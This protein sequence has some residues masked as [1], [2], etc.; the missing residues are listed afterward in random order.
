MSHSSVATETGQ[1]YISEQSL[2]IKDK[3]LERIKSL[4]KDTFIDSVL[5]DTGHDETSLSRIRNVL[6]QS[7]KEVEGF[8]N[9]QLIKRRKTRAGISLEH[10]LANDCY[11]LCIYLQGGTI[12]ELSDL[13]VCE[14][15]P[16]DICLSQSQACDADNLPSI[17]T[18]ESETL[19]GIRADVIAI[20]NDIH[21]QKSSSSAFD[22]KTSAALKNIKQANENEIKSIRCDMKK[23]SSESKKETSAILIK[24][25]C[26]DD[27][28]TDLQCKIENQE[29]TI[30]NLMSENKSLEQ[31]KNEST[32]R[33]TIIEK[34]LKIMKKTNENKDHKIATLIES[35]RDLSGKIE[36]MERTVE[37]IKNPRDHTLSSL[38]GDLKLFKQTVH[39]LKRD[40]DDF[41]T[42]FNSIKSSIAQ[43]RTRINTTDKNTSEIKAKLSSVNSQPCAQEQYEILNAKINSLSE[44]MRTASPI[45]TSLQNGPPRD[46]ASSN[47]NFTSRPNQAC[48]PDTHQAS[49]RTHP[50]KDTTSKSSTENNTINRPRPDNHDT[51][52][53]ELIH[54]NN[55]RI[56]VI[57]QVRD[58][59]KSL[60][61]KMTTS[62]D[63]NTYTSADQTQGYPPAMSTHPRV[64][65]YYIG[66]IDQ[67]VTTE[68]I[69]AHLWCYNIFIVNL[70]LFRSKRSGI[71]AAKLTVPVEHGYLLESPYF[72]PRDVYTRLWHA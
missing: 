69:A 40:T 8:P 44:N 38:K 12:D 72:W 37:S 14:K 18:I 47:V 65:D 49:R 30:T 13:F 53:D 28:F 45:D 24:L 41:T 54:Q 68:M 57:V 21:D 15:I 64:T 62:R 71:N 61:R 59:N 2:H 51:Q 9:R 22:H 33:L 23:Y 27:K 20:K 10:K 56:P 36:F 6:Y 46:R 1:S 43:L 63:N 17:Q 67:N 25:K 55:S 60:N 11:K 7:A 5:H 42:Q 66:N 29:A 39:E 19:A 48:S 58:Q 16:S 35:Q 31:A 32:R 3:Y 4:P 70:R 50:N 26:F 34:D 52:R